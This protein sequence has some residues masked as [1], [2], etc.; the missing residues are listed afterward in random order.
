MF[1]AFQLLN[2]IYCSPFCTTKRDFVSST[3]S[4]IVIHLVWTLRVRK[5]V[6]R[7][8]LILRIIY[9]I[10]SAM[11]T[12]VLYGRCLAVMCRKAACI[13]IRRNRH[14]LNLSCGSVRLDVHNTEC[15]SCADY[16][17]VPLED[18]ILEVLT[19]KSA[20]V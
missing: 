14:F 20:H 19:Y 15:K 8:I 4:Y 16:A 17:M 10:Y 11:T 12:R 1:I 18:T 2:V 5:G 3:R 9:C 7:I 13:G 6:Q